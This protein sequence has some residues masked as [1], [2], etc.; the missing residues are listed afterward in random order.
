MEPDDILVV[1]FLENVD[2]DT[3]DRLNDRLTA[4]LPDRKVVVLGGAAKLTVLFQGSL[5]RPERA[6]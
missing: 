6:A 2:C 4:L 5:S 3:L 1:T